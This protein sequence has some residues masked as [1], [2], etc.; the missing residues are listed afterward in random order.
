MI[1]PSKHIRLSE[2]IIGFAGYI[3]SQLVLSAY[4]VDEIW[5]MCQSKK[6]GQVC[7]SNQ[8]Y[9]NLVKALDLLYMMGLVELND[10]GKIIKV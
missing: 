9:D 10:E 3:L 6:Y 1:L 5:D 4:S 8:S 2:S 7:F